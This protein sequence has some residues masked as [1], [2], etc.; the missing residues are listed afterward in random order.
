MPSLLLAHIF[1]PDARQLLAGSYKLKMFRNQHFTR[2]LKPEI[3]LYLE[4][5][6]NI[7]TV[8]SVFVCCRR[9][10]TFSITAHPA[11]DQYFCNTKLQHM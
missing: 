7:S 2:T 3:N 11:N 9:D 6:G 10:G 4:R 5:S 1:L 8:S